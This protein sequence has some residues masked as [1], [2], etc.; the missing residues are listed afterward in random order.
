M[1]E[2]AVHVPDLAPPHPQRIIF[3]VDA[4]PAVNDVAA[5]VAAQV[6]GVV[7]APDENEDADQE[8]NDEEPTQNVHASAPT[9]P[10]LPALLISAT[11][12]AI[13]ACTGIFVLNAKQ[14]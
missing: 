8:P 11:V 12:A 2:Y 3:C 9:K 5:N 10:W 14:E 6:D 4:I 1:V 7:D 13:A